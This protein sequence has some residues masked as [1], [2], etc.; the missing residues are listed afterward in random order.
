MEG[1]W[2]GADP[3]SGHS[4]EIFATRFDPTGQH[5][6]SGSMDRSICKSLA[7]VNRERTNFKTK[8]FGTPTAPVKT[9]ES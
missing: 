3:I 7:S 4:G 5:I 1:Y 8:C 9:T 6:A 2:T